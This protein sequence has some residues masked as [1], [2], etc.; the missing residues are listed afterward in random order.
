[1]N[2]TPEIRVNADTVI[3]DGETAVITVRNPNDPIRGTWTYD[4]VVTADPEISGAIGDQTGVTTGV[5]N[6]TLTNSGTE[7]H[8]VE[9]HFTPR[10]HPDD[11]GAECGGGR[12]T[13]VTVWVEPIPRIQVTAPDTVICNDEDVAFTIQ[14][15]NPNTRGE[16]KYNLA[17]DYGAYIT[18]DNIG[19][20]YGSSD[21]YLTDHLVNH[22]TAVH[23]VSYHYTPRITPDDMGLDCG[24][25]RDTTIWVWVNPTPEIRVNIT[26]DT[27]ICNEDWIDLFVR[28]PNIPVR[29]D[30]M[31][32][33]DID[34]GTYITGDLTDG[35]Y[36][37]IVLTDQLINHDTV[38]HF[39]DYHFTPRID[40]DDFG[41]DCL[42]G[43]DTTIRVW[44]NPTPAIRVRA[45]D[46]IICN[47]EPAIIHVNNPN[48]FVI[49][50]WEYNLV[51]TPDPGITG[52]RPKCR[53]DH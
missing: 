40:P 10:I 15:L 41:P 47:G 22:D 44:V 31:Y 3:C 6:E 46:S 34:Y 30:W 19:G 45:Q 26:P 11:L 50:D 36:T 37:D 43:I 38:F 29:G 42:N 27:V 12:D 39:V 49:G 9:Y 32:Y 25:G 20:E 5:Y 17:V 21:T 33:L 1:M 8:K 2:P 16:W 35:D 51:V 7:A 4:L 48:A 28:N 23:A 52:A 24:S 18:G 53:W 13:I 14:N